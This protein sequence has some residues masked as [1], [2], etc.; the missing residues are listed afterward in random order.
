MGEKT[1]VFKQTSIDVALDILELFSAEKVEAG[2]SE[3]AR[4]LGKKA[5]TIHRTM[6]VL[7][8]R[9]Y[10]E[11]S[12][13][14]GK[15]KLGLKAF[16]LGCVYQNQCDVIKDATRC[17]ELLSKAT[18]ETINLAVIDQGMKEVAYIAKIES[19]QVLKTDI[20]IGT[21][22]FAH[23]TALGKV[24]LSYFDQPVIDMLFPPHTDLPTYTP[25]S[26]SNTDQL[27]RV[28]PEIRKAGFVF[29]NEEFRTGVICVAMPFRNMSN[30][31]VAA[32]S[33]TAPV[34]R[35]P[36]ERMEEFK[37]IMFEVLGAPRQS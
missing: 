2:V 24:L 9:G 34:S 30:R 21:K 27:R 36:A 33:I 12:I 6:K 4:F 25:K 22:I 3:M 28:L 35:C 32:M 26:I 19:T 8:R 16:E 37:A 15:Y 11:Q 20:Q 5:S 31:V 13:K 10:I 23:C 7:R 1:K 18:N 14:R 29:D 17:M